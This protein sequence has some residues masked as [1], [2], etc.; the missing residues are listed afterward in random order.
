[1]W[2]ESQTFAKDSACSIVRG[3]PSTRNVL[4]PRAACFSMAHRS[5]LF[6]S[7][8]GTLLPWRKCRSMAAHCGEGGPRLLLAAASSE[9]SKSPTDR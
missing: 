7:V 5:T 6:A 9:R 4:S 8:G 1:M 3:K 2:I